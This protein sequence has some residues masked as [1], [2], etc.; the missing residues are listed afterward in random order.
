[1]IRRLIVRCINFRPSSY[2]HNGRLSYDPV[3]PS[4]C[5]LV[6]RS[7]PHRPSFT[8]RDVAASVPSVTRPPSVPSLT[9]PPAAAARYD[10]VNSILSEFFT[11]RLEFYGKRKVH[12]EG[13]LGAE[14]SRLSN[15]ARS[16]PGG[17]DGRGG[18]G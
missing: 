5:L 2:R 1:M 10:D 9:P 14:S 4:H 6:S 12:L 18:E 8:V 13:L 15:Q 17:G 16:V 11:L 7:L 3:T